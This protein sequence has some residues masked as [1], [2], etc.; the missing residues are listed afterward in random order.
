MPSD[1]SPD[2]ISTPEQVRALRDRLHA[3]GKRLVFTN[4][5]F[6]LL[7]AGHVRYLNEARAL[8]DALVVAVNSDASVRELK[9][10]SR[11]INTAEDRAEILC[12]LRA[13]DAVCVFSEPRVTALIDT[14]RPH[15]YAKGGDYTVETLN[16]E[17]RGALQRVDSKIHLLQLVPGRSTT[18]TLKRANAET[19]A[20]PPP[21]SKSS[22]KRKLRIAVL[23][24]GEGS[25]F[26][27]IAGAIAA[28]K[29][30]GEIVCVISD[31]EDSGIAQMA[32]AMM[33]PCHIVDGGPNPLRF[34]Q[35]A[36]QAVHDHLV[37]ARPHIV[38]L[39]G[40]MRLL[41]EPTLSAFENRIINV[42]PSLL[43]KYRG[44]NAVQRA[45]DDGELVT[46]TTLHIV[47]AE[48]DAGRIL[49]Q[50]EV[51]IGIGD[52]VEEVTARIKNAEHELLPKVLAEWPR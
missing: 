3:E 16:P 10:P 12:A 40:F 32:Q 24:S 6:D 28:G 17:E 13:V 19:A 30:Y 52:T 41:K 36:Q 48:L 51:P 47:N 11:P 21:P 46:G 29:L 39:A 44:S 31:R 33:L 5:C 50:V 23:G 8:G 34:P 15:D 2:F 4:G 14:I 20:E 35:A 42:H 9:G 37:A 43:P 18:N 1:A 7:H 25:N 45:I 38:V 26:K 22:A 27:A 49:A